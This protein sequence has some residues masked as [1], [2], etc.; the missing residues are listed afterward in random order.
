MTQREFLQSTIDANISADVTDYAK[1]E[2]AKM[3]ARN[4]KR[5]NTPSKA[6]LANEPVKESI[7][8]A[9]ANGAMIASEIATA[10]GITPQ[11]ASSLCRVLTNEGKLVAIDVKAKSGTVKQYELA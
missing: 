9:L 7:L 5:R 1:A 11:K 10:C 4:E 6:Q 2:L 8:A 3:D